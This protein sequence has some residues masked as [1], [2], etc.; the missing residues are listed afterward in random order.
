MKNRIKVTKNNLLIWMLFFCIS[1]LGFYL[2][3]PLGKIYLIVSVESDVSGESQLFYGFRGQGFSEQRS[4]KKTISVGYNELNFPIPL[5]WQVIRWDPIDLPAA[6]MIVKNIFFYSLGGIRHFI[7]PEDVTPLSGVNITQQPHGVG[8]S[9]NGADPKILISSSVANRVFVLQAAVISL[10]SS[11]I[12]GFFTMYYLRQQGN[13][14][15]LIRL[16]NIIEKE[17]ATLRSFPMFFVFALICCFTALTTFSLSIDNEMSAIRS[18]HI[19]WV[20]EGRW[21]MALFQILIMPQA[22]V[23]YLPNLLFIFFMSIAYLFIIRAHDLKVNFYTYALFPIFCA[24]PTWSFLSSYY[25]NIPPT[26]LGVLLVSVTAWLFRWYILEWIITDKKIKWGPTCYVL[27]IQIVLLATA[28]GIYQ[29]F[30]FAF[31]SIALSIIVFTMLIKEINVR[32][33]IK[34]LIFLGLLMVLALALYYLIHHLAL[35]CSRFEVIYLK[36]FYNQKIFFNSPLEITQKVFFEAMKI[37]GGQK[38]LYGTSLQAIGFLVILGLCALIFNNSKMTTF[39][40]K[41]ITVGLAIIILGAP[42]ILNFMA[43]GEMPLRTF[44][45]VPYIIWFFSLL[46]LT[47]SQYIIRA[48]AIILLLAGV[49]Q[50]FYANSQYAA[51]M[52]MIEKQDEMLALSIYQEIVKVHPDFSRHRIYPVIFHGAKLSSTI[53][54]DVPTTKVAGSFFSWDGGHPFRMVVYMNLLGFNNL[55][56]GVLPSAEYPDKAARHFQEMPIWPALG[57]VKVVEGVTLVRLG[58]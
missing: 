29:T 3:T 8:L 19:G 24:F 54:P 48:L 55:Q 32:K 23:P 12:A 30:F 39:K 36:G 31:A 34:A 5:P 44:V 14:T 42:F 1:F 20:S 40:G 37:Y 50:I 53:Y 6:N 46:A 13:R 49:Y 27:S 43:G 9:I 4:I 33:I 11:I 7:Y 45:G 25:A 57:S 41:I 47:S 26:G 28:V 58:E 2:F 51:S 22:V 18:Q 35:W 15:A 21:G 17:Q 10:F 38:S 56:L 16:Q 52:Q